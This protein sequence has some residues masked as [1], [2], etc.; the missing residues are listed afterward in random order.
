MLDGMQIRVLGLEEKIREPGFYQLPIERHHSQ[1]CDGPSVT[2]T[3]LRKLT[4]GSPAD[5]WAFSALNPDRFERVETRA[6]V[7]GQ[8]MAAYIEAGEDGLAERFW[9]LPEDKPN[10]PTAAQ[11]KAI[12]EGRGTEA[13][14]KSL[15]FWN[16]VAKDPRQVLTRDEWELISAMGRVVRT[17][18]AAQATLG[19]LP[20]ITMAWF[21]EPSQLWCLSR[22]D[23]MSFDGMISDYKK[24]NTQG[25][26]F[27][28]QACDQKITAYGYDQQMGFAAEGFERLTGESPSAVGLVFQ[29]DEPPYSVILRAVSEEDLQLATFQNAEAR[30]LFRQ[31]LDSGHWPGPGEV[32]GTYR[33]PDWLREKILETMAKKGVS[34]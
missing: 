17:D 4:M 7:T 22:P 5:Y 31:C 27:T 21:D 25:R 16:R 23:Q 18:P 6:L 15:D 30:A 34:L 28:A 19:G 24:V 26:P 1:P 14:F 32:I 10:R 9:I 3:V 11:I 13:G 33:R 29:Q 2:S 12:E 8:A 20:E